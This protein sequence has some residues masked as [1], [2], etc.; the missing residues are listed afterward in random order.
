MLHLY[1]RNWFQS[2]IV[3]PVYRIVQNIFKIAHF[4]NY[5]M[6]G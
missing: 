2:Q 3:S 5:H 6:K 1:L 4:H